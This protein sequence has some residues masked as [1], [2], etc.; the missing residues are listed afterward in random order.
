MKTTINVLV[1]LV[2]IS[3]FCSN[4]Y[5]KFEQDWLELQQY[6][7]INNRV[8]SAEIWQTYYLCVRLFTIQCIQDDYTASAS[9]G[10]EFPQHFDYFCGYI[11][12]RNLKR[13]TTQ[14]S[15]ISPTHHPIRLSF[16]TFSLQHRNYRCVL[17]KLSIKTESRDEQFCGSR[18]PWFADY[19]ENELHISFYSEFLEFD[20]D[21]FK[22]QYHRIN[23]LIYANT[24]ILSLNHSIGLVA[25]D[26]TKFRSFHFISH[27]KFQTV[28]VKPE[29]QCGD[30]ICHDGPGNLS[31]IVKAD[32]ETLTSTSY[33]MRCLVFVRSLTCLSASRMHYHF[34][35]VVLTKRNYVN[36]TF[37]TWTRSP[38]MPD[39]AYWGYLN[40]DGDM[41]PGVQP[42][43]MYSG[44]EDPHMLLE[45]ES[46]IYGGLVFYQVSAQVANCFNCLIG[47]HFSTIKY[48]NNR[49]CSTCAM[50]HV[51]SNCTICL[52]TAS[53]STCIPCSYLTEVWTHCTTEIDKQVYLNAH[54]PFLFVHNYYRQYST[55]TPSFRFRAYEDPFVSFIFC[56]DKNTSYGINSEFNMALITSKPQ[57][58]INVQPLHASQ[59]IYKKYVFR[60]TEP[61]SILFTFYPNS[62]EDYCVYCKTKYTSL[63]NFLIE[64]YYDIIH[65]DKG[66]SKLFVNQF[67]SPVTEISVHLEKCKQVTYIGW[68]LIIE[69]TIRII[70]Y[71][72]YL[73]YMM[74]PK[75]TVVQMN[76]TYILHPLSLLPRHILRFRFEY[77]SMDNWWFMVS[78]HNLNEGIWKLT[79]EIPC[80]VNQVL[81]EVLSANGGHSDL[82][83][84]KEL[85]QQSEP[86]KQVTSW[87]TGCI[88]CI[89]IFISRPSKHTHLS[90]NYAEEARLNIDMQ[91]QTGL[92]EALSGSSQNL[93]QSRFTFYKYR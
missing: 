13:K 15:I 26:L 2:Y 93:M 61:R 14:W 82:Y 41:D 9:G 78:T 88:R 6:K 1:L 31:P 43:V 19:F 45:G 17:Q 21:Y 52:N 65:F 23:N 74:N 38:D 12:G 35:N 28:Q 48:L 30:V 63:S 53:P 76:Q 32:E 62:Q 29:F 50:D 68:Q 54:Y 27:Y 18:S 47:K 11:S 79:Q 91:K 39:S 25:T 71:T 83:L 34:Q 66:L 58:H 3:F 33:Q 55:R 92:K 69:S 84:W 67:K 37:F 64:D 24:Y 8:H 5:A 85:S 60:F 22:L 81:L 49:N 44:G 46:C 20:F 89:I 7:C 80:Q 16:L 4:V 40:S 73:K 42:R 59:I 51:V 56:L 72:Q 87:I 86:R 75:S 57:F 36:E 77:L 70:K 10:K 90:C